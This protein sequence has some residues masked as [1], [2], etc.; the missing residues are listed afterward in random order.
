MWGYVNVIR[1]RLPR[2][3][4]QPSY[5]NRA[6]NIPITTAGILAKELINSPK[7]SILL[8]LSLFCNTTTL[9]RFEAVRVIK[10]VDI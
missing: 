8:Y 7:N 4:A 6:P 9:S 5:V 1:R 3:I 10:K 2:R